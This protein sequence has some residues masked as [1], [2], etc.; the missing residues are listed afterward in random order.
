MCSVNQGMLSISRDVQCIG[1]YYE[2]LRGYLEYIV[3]SSVHREDV[4]IL[5]GA[6]YKYIMRCSVHWGRGARI[7]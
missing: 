5:V 7:S 2:F 3:R 1:G 4:T 6:Y